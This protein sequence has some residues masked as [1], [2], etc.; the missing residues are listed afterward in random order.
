MKMDKISI[1]VLYIYVII[2][3]NLTQFHLQNKTCCHTKLYTVLDRYKERDH[4]IQCKDSACSNN[5]EMVRNQTNS[6][7]VVHYQ[8]GK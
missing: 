2:I 6:D 3:S 5:Q 7:V 4:L 8:K 1:Q